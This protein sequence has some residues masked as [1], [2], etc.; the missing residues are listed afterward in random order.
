MGYSMI[1]AVAVPWD[2]P[3]GAAA[4]ERE[5]QLQQH[6]RSLEPIDVWRE[7]FARDVRRAAAAVRRPEREARLSL[8]ERALSLSPDAL[9]QQ[10]EEADPW[11]CVDLLS[12]VARPMFEQ[13]A[14]M[15]DSAIEELL[16]TGELAVPLTAFDASLREH[17]SQWVNGRWGRPGG[18]VR[19]SDVD[20]LPRF[21]DP[22]ERWEHSYVR[23]WWSDY[24]L[25]LELAVPDVAG[26]R[27]ETVHMGGAPPYQARMPLVYLG[28]R[29]DAPECRQAVEEEAAQWQSAQQDREEAA[30]EPP[31]EYSALIPAPNETDPRLALPV[32]LS[33]RDGGRLSL[34]GGLERVARQCDVAVVANYLPAEYLSVDVAPRDGASVTA[35]D[36]LRALR[37]ERSGALSWNSYGSYLVVRDAEHPLLDASVVPGE[38]DARWKALLTPGNPFTLDSFASVLASANERQVQT[39]EERDLVEQPRYPQVYALRAYGL[40]AGDERQRLREAESLP[41]S[42]LSGESQRL[43]VMFGR[44]ERPWLQPSDLTGGVA[45]LLPRTLS[46]G[47]PGVSLIVEYGDG[48]RD[49][50]LTA[51]LEFTVTADGF[52][53]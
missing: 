41:V 33:G 48:D 18:R 13:V 32:D 38:L 42:T 4:E 9:L 27:T 45:R 51:P 22:E 46:S 53:M 34:S 24:V 1:G 2:S 8:Y 36:M 25:Y 19:A 30:E 12:P 26:Y 47:R 16:A 37:R 15:E 7:R 50:L 11:L 20:R 35:G 17:L 21:T 39:W 14:A 5:Y 10:Y 3:G 23:L 6:E 28:Y 43:F 29:D 40:L 31:L 49:V 52:I 44:R